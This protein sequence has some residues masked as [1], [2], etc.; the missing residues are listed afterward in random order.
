M[1][2]GFIGAGIMG[3]GMA[4]NLL[5]A[6]HDLKVI[7]HRNRVPIDDLISHGAIEAGSYA[8]LAV[9]SEVVVLCVTGTPVAR[10]VIANLLPHLASGAMVI[11]TTTNEPDGPVEFATEL[12]AAGIHYVEAPVTGGVKQAKDGVLGAIVGCDEAVFSKAKD[13]LSCFCKQV[14]HFGPVGMGARAK[15]VS[16]FLALGTATLVV[17]TF[18]QARSLGVDW[19]KLYALAQLGSGNSSG[20]QRIL[21]GALEGD[22]RGYVFSIGNTVKDFS[23]FCKLAENNGEAPELA[24]VM[25]SIYERAVAEGHGDRMLSELL[26]P[27]LGDPEQG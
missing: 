5:R 24:P 26:D 23:Y 8:D 22:Y 2:I 9:G 18:K 21:G 20:L 15:L 14:E 1:K 4:L 7:A 3:H 16:N 27:A 6:G 25:K 17:E 10:T 13:I 12:A 19:K 11:D